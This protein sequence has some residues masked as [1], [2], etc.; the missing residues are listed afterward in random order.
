MIR[1]IMIVDDS[2]AMRTFIRRVIHLAGIEV[3]ACLEAS[4]GSEALETLRAEKP[5]AILTD[6]NM[7]VMDG[8][9]LMRHLAE[10][11]RLRSIPVLVVSMDAS[12]CR[13]ERM[14]ALGA[15][16]YLGKPFRPE[17]LR[18]AIEAAIGVPHVKGGFDA[19]LRESVAEALEEMFF[20]TDLEECDPG[21][22]SPDPMLLA[23]VD[24]TGAPSGQLMLRASLSAARSLAADFLGEAEDAIGDSQVTDVFAE[25]ANIV[26]GAVLTRT[27]GACT[28]CLSSPRVLSLE[29]NSGYIEYPSTEAAGKQSEYVVDLPNGPLAVLL[30]TEAA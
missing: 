21:A 2:P 7:P 27:E 3:A 23:L 1:R 6:V 12:D 8:E 30:R 24:F 13:M 11:E 10:E 29:E 19:A 20:V 9:E 26:C 28:F 22:S 17:Q 18:D 14:K 5:D 15:R 16:G 4:N 25:L